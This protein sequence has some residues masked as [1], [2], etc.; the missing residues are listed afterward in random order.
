MNQPCVYTFLPVE[1]AS[2][3]GGYELLSQLYD[4][5]HTPSTRWAC[6]F[7]WTRGQPMHVHSFIC[8]VLHCRRNGREGGI[9]NNVPGRKTRWM[10]GESQLG[11]P[12]NAEPKAQACCPQGLY[13]KPEARWPSEKGFR[14]KSLHFGLFRLPGPCSTPW[15][16]ELRPSASLIWL[17]HSTSQSQWKK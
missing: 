12:E 7:I 9:F 1:G 10:A 5:Q 17:M 13:L 14:N 3:A 15:V 2:G 6:F 8:W 16:G 11:T 4:L